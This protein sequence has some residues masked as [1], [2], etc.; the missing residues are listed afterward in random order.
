L[1][2]VFVVPVYVEVPSGFERAVIELESYLRRAGYAF[3]TAEPLAEDLE[4]T[5]LRLGA[6]F[7]VGA[8][9]DVG[10]NFDAGLGAGQS[11]G[12]VEAEHLAEL[13]AANPGA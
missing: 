12:V 4:A 13:R 2:S 6:N 8:N 10:V 9:F 5:K 3:C 11:S 7:G 1:P